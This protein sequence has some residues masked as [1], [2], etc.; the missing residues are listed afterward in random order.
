MPFTVKVKI[1]IKDLKMAVLKPGILLE[2]CQLIL[3]NKISICIKTFSRRKHV[4]L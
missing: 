4:V 3:E 1:I 2:L